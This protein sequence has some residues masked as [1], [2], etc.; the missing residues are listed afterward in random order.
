VP[1]GNQDHSGIP[2][3]VPVIAYGLD[4]ALDLFLGQVLPRA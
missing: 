2:V 4:E 3:A 1:E